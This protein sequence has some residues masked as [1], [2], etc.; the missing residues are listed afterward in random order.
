MI[1]RINAESLKDQFVKQF[2]ENILSGYFSIGEKLPSERD[3]ATQMGVSRPVVHEGLVDLAAKGLV[4][5]KP[6]HGT[7]VNDYRKE[8]SLA[9]LHSLM[10]YRSHGVED[11]LLKS[12]LNMRMLFEVENARLAALNRSEEQLEDLF[13]IIKTEKTVNQ[14]NLKKITELDFNFHHTISLATGN[15]IYPLMLNSM[16]QFYTNISGIFF[17]VKG[18]I[19]VVFEFHAS[20]VDAVIEKDDKKAVSVMK[21][22]LSHGELN[23]QKQRL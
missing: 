8:G 13:K 4:T 3:I 5:M 16:K 9:L 7:I 21:K 6:R 10:Q 12:L 1:K 14:R 23:L 18:V 19:P 15:V 11:E 2:E 22:M 20:I 17:K